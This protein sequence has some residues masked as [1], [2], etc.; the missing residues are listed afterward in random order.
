MEDLE[1]LELNLDINTW[2]PPKAQRQKDNMFGYG[3][4]SKSKYLPKIN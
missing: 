4:D 2:G 3:A 1:N